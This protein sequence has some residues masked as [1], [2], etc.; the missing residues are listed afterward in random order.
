MVG[1]HGVSSATLSFRWG[2]LLAGLAASALVGYGDI[3]TGELTLTSLYLAIIFGTA[4]FG[5]RWPGCLMA[6]VDLAWVML[7]NPPLG[8]TGGL[9][10]QRIVYYLIESLGTAIVFLSCAVLADRLRQSLAWERLQNLNLSRY[11]PPELADRLAREG[12]NAMRARRVDAAMLF[13]DIRDFTAST[14]AMEPAALFDFLQTFRTLVA[15][16]VEAEDGVLDKFLGD[17]VLAVFGTVRP[18]TSDAASAIR[19]AR[20]LLEAIAAWNADR[21]NGG[22]SPV[23][24]GIGVHYGEI[25]A[26]AIGDE[27]RLEY[28]IVGHAVNVCSRIERL[29]KKYDVPLLVSEQ[30][31]AAATESGMSFEGWCHM[32]DEEVPGV[33]GALRLVRPALP[34]AQRTSAAKPQS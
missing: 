7:A 22:E 34:A 11:L 3:L 30:A 13:M 24:V 4:W 23:R 21:A 26:G 18:R 1:P 10:G 5:G 31:V 33:S 8:L 15:R 2:V 12:L 16:V 6:A 29:T 19:C 9:S 17:G 25:V 32:V 28:S 20:R 14:Q 27:R